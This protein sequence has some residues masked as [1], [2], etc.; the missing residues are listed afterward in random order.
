MQFCSKLSSKS[1]NHFTAGFTK[2]ALRTAQR[3]DHIT[4]RKIYIYTHIYTHI[5]SSISPEAL[6]WA[7][8]AYFPLFLLDFQPLP[9]LMCLRAAYCHTMAGGYTPPPSH[10]PTFAITVSLFCSPKCA[11]QVFPHAVEGCAVNFSV[12]SM[13]MDKHGCRR[14]RQQ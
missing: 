4:K 3:E 12:G 8:T 1:Y 13:R 7:L 6:S 5:G 11:W 14:Q 10:H 9:G 2:W